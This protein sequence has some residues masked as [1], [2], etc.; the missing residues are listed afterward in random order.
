MTLLA[1]VLTGASV[2]LLG[3]PSPHRR[4]RRVLGVAAPPREVDRGILVAAAV[5]L[6]GTL[7]VGWPWGTLA[8]GVAAPFVRERVA[9]AR[10]PSPIVPAA[11]PLTL[12]LVAAALDAGRPPG[13][14]VAAAARAMRG[15]VG[16]E[17]ADLASRLVTVA[18]PARVWRDATRHPNLAPLARALVRAERSGAAPALVVTHAADDLR[19]R[20]QAEMT[21]RTRAGGVATALPL[22]LCF[23]PAF[24]LVGIVP[25]I[26]GLVGSVLG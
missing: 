17:L 22:G 11:V 8:G 18:D 6:A 21:R 24:F 10:R 3:G 23:L 15:E 5:V 7:V 25:T 13:A 12:D 9:R 4:A 16:A 19:R 20:R 14:A 1:A 26:L 2:L